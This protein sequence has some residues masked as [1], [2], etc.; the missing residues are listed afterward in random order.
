M[1]ATKFLTVVFI[2]LAAR[3]SQ[4]MVRGSEVVEEFHQSYALSDGGSVRLN[5]INGGVEIKVWDKREV[6]V[7]AEKRADDKDMMEQLQIV[8][9][10]SQDLV[11]IDTKYPDDNNTH[12]DH[13][14]WVEYTITVPRD[15]NLDRIK[16]I[17]G[18][19]EISGVGGKMNASTI[20]GIVRAS[21]VK[22][23]CILET[24]NGTID[25]DF[26]SLKSR[27]DLRIKSVNGSIAVNLPADLN[28]RIKAKTVSGHI[29]NDFGIVLSRD[30]DDH[31]FVKIGDSIDGK[32][33]NGDGYVNAETVNGSIKIL[34]SGEGK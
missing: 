20:N 24:V 34:K 27:C 13:G 10:A 3:S 26:A 2:C 17:N 32:I 21:D 18:D 8:V 14:P 22:N 12:N 33:G 6:E 19:I 11:D 30:S 9:N 15:A 29:S 25:A 1:K 28:A 5:N 7:D 31:S 23:D 4:A 16:I